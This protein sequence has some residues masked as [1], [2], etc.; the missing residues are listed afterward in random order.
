MKYSRFEML[1]LLF[2]GAA[3]ATTAAS[4]AARKTDVVE[5]IAQLLILVVLLGAL[6]WGRKGG[7]IASLLAVAGYLA[8]RLPM[9]LEAGTLS[10]TLI[11]LLLTRTVVYGALGIVGGEICSRIKYLF[12]KLEGGGHI[13]EV[14]DL[15]NASFLKHLMRTHLAQF[16]RYNAPFSLVLLKLDVEALQDVPKGRMKRL[17]RDG[18]AALLGDVRLVDEM[19]RFSD[20]TFCAILPNTPL[21]GGNVA[22]AR[23]EKTL[24]AS[25]RSKKVQG[26][27]LVTRE[28][29]AC[30]ENRAAIDELAEV[31]AEGLPAEAVIAPRSRSAPAKPSEA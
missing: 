7:Y 6:H 21:A 28:V 10:P 19:G 5:V 18:G 9:I 23:L 2:G 17:L 20:D 25:L 26:E 12:V 16:D 3:V 22:G 11:Q 27:T 31:E 4:A 14:T 8:L 30:P 1:V 13:D 15:Y 29:L 24:K